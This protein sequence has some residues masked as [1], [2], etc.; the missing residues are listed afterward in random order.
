MKVLSRRETR[1]GICDI[2]SICSARESYASFLESF[3]CMNFAMLGKQSLSFDSLIREEP[4]AL[5][6]LMTS[7]EFQ[8]LMTLTKMRLEDYLRMAREDKFVG[9]ILLYPNIAEDILSYLN[10]GDLKNIATR[11]QYYLLCVK[12]NGYLTL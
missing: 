4:L 5:E 2:H 12:R 10:G 1:I 7:K 6:S 9:E 3:S 8:R 11:V